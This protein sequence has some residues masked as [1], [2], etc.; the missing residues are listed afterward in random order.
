M[1]KYHSNKERLRAKGTGWDLKESRL[2]LPFYDAASFMPDWLYDCADVHRDSPQLSKRQR[3]SGGHG[4][5][6]RRSGRTAVLE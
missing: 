6:F 3:R 2:A 4:K 1:S 5:L